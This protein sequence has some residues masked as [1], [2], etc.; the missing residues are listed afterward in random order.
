MPNV[1][2]IIGKGFKY[3]Q[4]AEEQKVPPTTGTVATILGT[5]HWGPIDTPI[6]INDGLTEFRGRFGDVSSDYDEGHQ[7]ALYHYARSSRGYFTRISDGTEEKS[8]YRVKADD[9]AA[10]SVSDS[11]IGPDL[12]ILVSGVSDALTL[13]FDDTSD[14]INETVNVTFTGTALATNGYQDITN[15]GSLGGF[16]AATVPA[17]ATQSDYELDITI[18]GVLHQLADISINVADDWTDIAAAIQTSLQTATSGTETVALNGTAGSETIR[19]TSA[20]T[21]GTTSTVLIA[22]GTAGTGSGD[23]LAVITALGASYTAT[24]GTAVDGLNSDEAA[25]VTQINAAVA[26]N[27]ALQTAY[28]SYVGAADFAPAAV[29][30]TGANANKLVI[31]NGG[32][33]ADNTLV[34]SGTATTPIP[35]TDTAGTT[36]KS[37]GTLRAIFTGRDGDRIRI[38]YSKI[39]ATENTLDFYFRNSQIASFVNVNFDFT[40]SDVNF[41]ENIINNDP[42]LQNIVE[43]LHAQ[44][45]DGVAL[46]PTVLDTEV[47][48]DEIDSYLANGASGDSSIDVVTD[49]IP[50]IT[51]YDSV[52]VYNFDMISAPGYYEE[53]V[54]D[55]IQ[56]VS[57]ERQDAMG[58]FDTPMLSVTNVIN[59]SNGLGGLGRTTRINNRF[60]AWYFPWIKVRKRVFT[61]SS[62]TV[63]IDSILNDYSP[64]TRVIGAISQA[65]GLAGTT[66]AARAGI[67][68]QMSDVEGFHVEISKTDR[69]KLYGD[70]YDGIINPLGFTTEDGFTIEGQK[71]GLRKNVNGNLTAESRMNVMAT[72]L[73]LKREIY[74]NSKFFFRNPTDPKTQADFKK[75]IESIMTVLEENRAIEPQSGQ[76]PWSVIVDASNNTNLVTSQN[77]LVA[78]LEWYA[79]KTVERIKVISNIREKSVTIEFV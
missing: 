45:E 58:I 44:D 78:E 60:G 38:V 31:T 26:L 72:G 29:P 11:A 63:D 47:W 16:P 27:S 22:A 6:R 62:S 57:E 61:S 35:M 68:T 51:K 41:V 21:F 8:W 43:Y 70:V 36:G 4:V 18:D 2:D 30:T 39:S 59:W 69:E 64:L 77:G 24:I 65:D 46:S 79:I 34:T 7:A 28:E 42:T 49:L 17:I 53:S 23:L 67:R 40:T 66:F 37:Y 50:E 10:Y 5:A 13:D 52:D 73:F 32:S 54:Q 48:P 9:T 1:S 56:T 75:M 76:Y 71:T 55:A 74:R 19:V 12:A 25:I 20:D 33:G 15:T 14:G 3:V